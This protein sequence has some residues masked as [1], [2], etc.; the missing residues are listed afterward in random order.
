LVFDPW[1]FHRASAGHDAQSTCIPWPRRLRSLHSGC[2]GLISSQGLAFI[3]TSTL[4]NL[5]GRPRPD[6]IARCIPRT[7]APAGTQFRLVSKA[8][9]AQSN[10][11]I[12]KDGE[13][14]TEHSPCLPSDPSIAGF[15]SFPSGHSSSAFA[16]LGYLSLYCAANLRVADQRGDFWRAFLV[17]FP[18]LAAAIV[19]ATR[20]MDAQHHGF[21]VLFGAAL[22][23][24]CA[25][26]TYRQYY[27]PISHTW[28][29]GR[30]YSLKHWGMPRDRQPP[31][32]SQT[33]DLK[34][35]E[36]SDY[37]RCESVDS[38]TLNT[39]DYREH[40]VLYHH[41]DTAPPPQLPDFDLGVQQHCWFPSRYSGDSSS[42]IAAEP[43]SHSAR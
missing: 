23:L 31:K 14:I 29:R 34:N 17:L 3:I 37:P 25:W 15:R 39:E 16:G 21:D 40:F 20:I 27:P 33:T 28:T 8:I 32:D 26:I 6:L 12:L 4:K 24:L 2:L 30:P 18:I 10:V 38:Q 42:A 1:F 36:T 35:F 7:D 13:H 9:C 41:Q 19:A 5:C 22:E 43:A 11:G